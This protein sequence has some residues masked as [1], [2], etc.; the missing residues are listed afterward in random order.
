MSKNGLVKDYYDFEKE[1][2]E[3]Y[4]EKVIVFLQKGKFYELYSNKDDNSFKQFCNDIL[5]FTCTKSN[6]NK[7]FH[8]VNNPYMAGFQT[9]FIDRYINILLEKNYNIVIVDEY[10]KYNGEKILRNRVIERKVTKVISPST[11]LDNNNISSFMT[12]FIDFIEN[13]QNTNYISISVIELAFNNITIYTEKELNNG[14]IEYLK[15]IL[16][17]TNPKEIKIIFKMDK[18][19]NKNIITDIENIINYIL[20][21]NKINI[22]KEEV[23]NTFYKPSYQEQFLNKIY[24]NSKI[25]ISSVE[26]LNLEKY[27]LSVISLIYLIQFCVDH[28]SLIL[29]NFKK[30]NIID[31]SKTLELNYN[32]IDKLYI[33]DLINY[34]NCCSTPMGKRY[35]KNNILNPLNSSKTINNR[36]ELIKY[37]KNMSIEGIKNGDYKDIDNILKNIKYI[38]KIFIK[39]FLLKYNDYYLLYDS[40]LNLKKV[41]I[42]NNL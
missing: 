5:C 35:L 33:N 18:N 42:Y 22:Y 38:D 40:L 19:N 15:T 13:S 10:H 36:Y 1:Y 24:N 12:I 7:D 6:K 17:K 25:G 26:D 11:Y 34:I 30:P 21:N 20:T 31:E 41:F 32:C 3:K 4:G 2:K 16:L 28:D 8:P 39:L 29:N 14:F 37:F 23:D 27:P 9:N